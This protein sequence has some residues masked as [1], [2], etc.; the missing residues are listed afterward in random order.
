MHLTIR[1]EGPL[2]VSCMD[3]GKNITPNGIQFGKMISFITLK[4]EI[5]VCKNFLT[6]D[7]F[8]I[9]ILLFSATTSC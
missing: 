9:F 1:N 2:K 6:K 5:F 8:H 3:C 7:A 4:N